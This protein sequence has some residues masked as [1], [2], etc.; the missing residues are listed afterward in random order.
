[1]T[2]APPTP[3]P[4]SRRRRRRP[5]RA[6]LR[7]RRSALAVGILVLMVAL[8]AGVL[9]L[10]SGT[11]PQRR[12]V[13]PVAVAVRPRRALTATVVTARRAHAE[14]LAVQRA[15]R[16]APFVSIGG[17]AHRDIALTFD[18]GPGPYTPAI[19]RALT[20]AGAPATFFQVGF[21][22]HWFTDG[23]AL[24]VSDRRFALGDHTQSHGHLP[25]LSARD[26]AA[27]IDRQATVL[28][29]AGGPPPTLFRPPYGQFDATTLKLL[30]H[31]RM[32][33][34]LWSV[35]SR[36][37]L[38]PG[39]DAIVQRVLA[40]AEP[41]AIVLMHDAGG[42]RSQTVAAIPRIV[43]ALRRRHY[44]LV[45]VPRLLTDDPPPAR[46]KRPAEGV[47]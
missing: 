16:Q 40:G 23:E 33:M 11:H 43:T 39:V 28:R 24:E 41:G 6:Q 3:P 8:G 13:A 27:E 47:G 29:T 20:R 45:T 12:V 35:D 34:V 30:A 22:E 31:R 15:R 18:D 1:M 10:A 9:A 36:D 19:V 4:D 46:Q 17:R 44:N 32:L 37:Y 38:R 26:Q 25:S 7:R 21:S 5:T 2:E 42:D 14:G